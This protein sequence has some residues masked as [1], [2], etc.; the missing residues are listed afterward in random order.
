[1]NADPATV[2]HAPRALERSRLERGACSEHDAWR[3]SMITGEAEMAHKRKPRGDAGA[4]VPVAIP[5]AEVFL[6]EVRTL[7]LPDGTTP[8]DAIAAVFC[9]LE[10]RLPGGLDL[11]LLQR[12][13]EQIRPL[14]DRCPVHRTD[15]ALA[16]GR[17]E[18]LRQVAEH[19]GRSEADGERAARSVFA[20]AR[21][22]L[23]SPHLLRDVDRELPDDLREMWETPERV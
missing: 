19:L 13:P 15:P 14:L 23:E 5:P 22:V 9:T 18:F 16:F 3:V 4:R 11:R 21:K 1:V 17:A 20:A 12:F 8:A 7:G 6:T 10:R 2:A